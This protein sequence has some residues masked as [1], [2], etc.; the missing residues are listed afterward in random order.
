MAQVVAPISY[1][2]TKVSRWAVGTLAVGL[3]AGLLGAGVFL[4]ARRLSG[5]FV[6]PLGTTDLALAAISLGLLAVGARIATAFCLPETRSATSLVALL[7]PTA[8][9]VLIAA[10]LSLPGTAQLPLVI[11]WTLLVAEEVVVLD[12]LLRR[13]PKGAVPVSS[14]KI[15]TQVKRSTSDVEPFAED[16]DSSEENSSLDAS[17][18]DPSVT[19]KITRASGED[20][21]EVIHALLR[22][23]FVV[24]QRLVTLHV[25]FCPP[26]QGIP[27]IDLNQSAGP[28]VRIQATQ[29]QPFGM[30]IEARLERAADSPQSVTI[31]LLAQDSSSA[32]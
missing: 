4:S 20:G 17:T 32:V 29:V 28:S 5:A 27:H 22:G 26:L 19:Q 2:D 9:L 8:A 30:R 10:S 3:G 18:L 24:G 7:L 11:F 15:E 1:D 12:L 21:T 6:Q 14:V 16:E 23:D 25:A 31:E 13:L